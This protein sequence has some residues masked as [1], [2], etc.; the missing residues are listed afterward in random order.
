VNATVLTNQQIAAQSL[1][2]GAAGTALLHIERAMT[3]TGDWTTAHAAIRTAAAGPVDIAAHSSLYYGAPAIAFGLHVASSG[4][5]DRYGHA[6]D[7]ITDHVQRIAEQRLSAATASLDAGSVSF[8]DYDLFRGLTGIAALML[9][10]APSSDTLAG[11]L[12]YLAR[13]TQPRAGGPGWWV[14]HDPDPVLP[15]P[16][17]HANAGMAHGAAGILAVLALAATRGR[18]IDGQ[19]DAI[20]CLLAWFDRWRQDSPDGPWWPQWITHADL[21]SGRPAQYGPG[22]PSWCYGTPGIARAQQLAAQALGDKAR[23]AAA[24]QALAACLSSTQLTLLT[25]TGLCHGLA[26]L[27][28]TACRAVQDAHTGAIAERLPVLAA[29]L[30][31]RHAKPDVH[32]DGLLD[33]ET[34]VLLVLE[35]VQRNALP[36]SGWDACLLLS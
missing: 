21:R 31:R 28:Q 7:Q 36:R 25:S 26:G 14:P 13:L 17:G 19:L 10:I 4:G 30:T 3:G 8:A 32:H 20:R 15:T 18:I 6:L 23:A 11:I 2:I 16:G 9:R 22:R 29:V 35:A 24:E 27:W 1:A 34:G 33:G 5:N 12:A